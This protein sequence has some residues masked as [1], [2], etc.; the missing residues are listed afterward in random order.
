VHGFVLA[1]VG[2]DAGAVKP[3]LHSYLADRVIGTIKLNPKALDENEVFEATLATRAEHEREQ[4][5]RLVDE[6][7]EKVGAR[8]GANGVKPV[9]TALS[10]GQVRVLL[11]HHDDAVPGFRCSESGR[12]AL[13]ERDCRGEGDPVPVLDVIDEAIEE[14]LRQHVDINVLYDED[15]GS[16]VDGLAAIYRFR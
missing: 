3:F 2:A 5:R 7:R 4:E 9:L 16:A 6:L 8:W 13:T 12:L 14:A 11:V 15:A 1:G 10:R